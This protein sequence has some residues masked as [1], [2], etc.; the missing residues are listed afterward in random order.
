V[1]AWKLL[2]RMLRRGKR[3]WQIEWHE[4]IFAGRVVVKMIADDWGSGFHRVVVSVV[5]VELGG[6]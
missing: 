5:V 6:P 4:R 1:H 3:D 2:L